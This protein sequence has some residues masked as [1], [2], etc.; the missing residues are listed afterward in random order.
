[1]IVFDV[2]VDVAVV[3]LESVGRLYR[4]VYDVAP[5]IEPHEAVKDDVLRVSVTVGVAHLMSVLNVEADVVA[6][7]AY[8]V[9]S[10]I[11]VILYSYVV[12]CVKPVRLVLYVAF[13]IPTSP[14]SS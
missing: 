11:A 2:V 12:P 9:P 10:P 5:V 1:M 4:I 8:V 14:S 3:Q 6:E 13:A 7:L